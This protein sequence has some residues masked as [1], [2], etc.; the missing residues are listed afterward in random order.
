ML[1]LKKKLLS[2]QRE[3]TRKMLLLYPVTLISLKKLLPSRLEWDLQTLPSSV[4]TAPSGTCIHCCRSGVEYLEITEEINVRS[5]VDYLEITE[6]VSERAADFVKLS[7][8]EDC[9]IG[10]CKTQ[11]HID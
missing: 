3:V 11:L 1:T 4:P 8:T 9:G 10:L 7:T 5:G 6:D 2:A